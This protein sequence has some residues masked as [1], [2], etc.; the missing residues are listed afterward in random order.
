[1]ANG[2]GLDIVRC[3]GQTGQFDIRLSVSKVKVI[4]L[5]LINYRNLVIRLFG[6]RHVR[7]WCYGGWVDGWMYS[8]PFEAKQLVD[9]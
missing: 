2:F 1:M 6:F 9:E 8:I 7:F 5:F 3:F 4:G